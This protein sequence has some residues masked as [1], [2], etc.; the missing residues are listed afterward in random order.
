METCKTLMKKYES[1]TNN[2]LF[3]QEFDVDNDFGKILKII[4]QL[5]KTI[6]IFNFF[7][8]YFAPPCGG[9]P[10]IPWGAVTDK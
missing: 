2:F 10:S 3:H 9:E 1:G 8:I 7:L 4:N 6:M 5:R